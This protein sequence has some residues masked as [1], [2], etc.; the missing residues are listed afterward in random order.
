MDE[1]VVWKMPQEATVCW[2]MCKSENTGYWAANP[3]ERG[4]C[5]L[6]ITVAGL[7]VTKANQESPKVMAAFKPGSMTAGRI[8]S[9][10]AVRRRSQFLVVSQRPALG[11]LS[12]EFPSIPLF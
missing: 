4:S 9:L 11:S 7:I 2:E 8:Q 6:E 1:K 12:R 3:L 5:A 10:A